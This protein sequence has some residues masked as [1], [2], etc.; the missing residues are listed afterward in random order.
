M[1]ILNYLILKLFRY[2]KDKDVLSKSDP[3]CVVYLLVPKGDMEP[4]FIEIGRTEVIYNNLNPKWNA[5]IQLDY[6]FETKQQ[7]RFDVFDIDTDDTR[8]LSRQDFLG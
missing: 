6:Y 7:L 5:K 2:L 3:M 8:D 4:E 1:G